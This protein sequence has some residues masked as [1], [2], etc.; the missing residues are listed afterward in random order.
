MSKNKKTLKKS[1]F[2]I[3]LLTITSLG[4][5]GTAAYFSIFGLAKL[6]YGA[7]V[8]IIV[9]AT[10]LELSKLVTV[11]Y[12]Y[13][14]WDHIAKAL[15]AYYIFGILFIMLLTSIGI[16]GFL[17]SAYQST[18]NKLELRDSQITIAENK[19][20][21]FVAQLDRINRT[22]ESNNN[23]IDAL[24][25]ARNQQ[26]SR[27]NDLYS[28]NKVTSARRTES[29]ISSS[30]K[31]IE[32]LNIDITDKMTQSN[33][34]ND[35]IAFYDQKIVELKA[36][37]ISGEI[38]PLK[39]IS[40]LVNIPMN[41]VVNILVLLIIFVFDPMAITLLIGVNQL[42]MMERNNKTSEEIKIPF[43]KK[44]KKE[45]ESEKTTEPDVIS[46]KKIIQP[47]KTP[48]SI[49][50]ISDFIDNENDDDEDHDIDNN[51]DV[52]EEE[53]VDES[54]KN[55]SFQQIC[56]DGYKIEKVNLKL[57]EIETGLT[58]FHTT[59]GDGII[60][61]FDKDRSRLF[62][63]FGSVLRE[64]DPLYA[65]LKI[66]E[67][68]PIEPKTVQYIDYHIS[69]P[70]YNEIKEQ[71]PNVENKHAEI[72]EKNTF[73]IPEVVEKVVNE[74]PVSEKKTKLFHQFWKGKKIV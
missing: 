59:F 67:C 58:V 51:E 72:T 34:I 11:S 44:R 40:E 19:K 16:Y 60:T 39:Y 31:Q 24:T 74:K 2:F 10:V 45:E 4:L 38:G 21:V 13:R 30:D 55:E 70:E 42:T 32:T 29:Q 18:S 27:L 5:A 3:I 48:T 25:T 9:L 61:K 68:V 57:N 66:Y 37:D 17:T 22:I 63:K 47:I 8:G 6:F 43:I 46:V 23:R 41:Q 35:S 49:P 69:D 7:G 14:Y 56:P 50:I 1:W 33:V 73:D 64:L 12:V 65:N 54:K 62:I 26:E 71:L 52:D 15:R 53:Y 20:G 28:G 36:S